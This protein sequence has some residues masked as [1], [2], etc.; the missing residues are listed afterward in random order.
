MINV[1]S[2]NYQ[3]KYIRH[4]TWKWQWYWNSIT[5]NEEAHCVVKGI[6]QYTKLC[7]VS[8]TSIFMLS[9]WISTPIN[10]VRIR[11]TS[12]LLSRSWQF[13]QERLSYMLHRSNTH[14]QIP[15]RLL[16][17]V[18]NYTADTAVMYFPTVSEF[19]RVPRAFQV[20]TLQGHVGAS[21]CYKFLS[22]CT[23][24]LMLWSRIFGNIVQVEFNLDLIDL[25]SVPNLYYCN[26]CFKINFIIRKL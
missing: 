14:K 23:F 20:S 12:I 11:S 10:I 16:S 9:S 2:E 5:H 25:I 18:E 6:Q 17:S 19:C 24:W 7:L 26:C 13:E 1:V 4:L 8:P 21:A 22:T 3:T 15:N